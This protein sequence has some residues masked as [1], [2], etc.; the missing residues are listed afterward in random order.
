MK[1]FLLLLLPALFFSF[2]LLAG[3]GGG[4]STPGTPGPPGPPP[5]CAASPAAGNT[6][7]TATPI[8]NLNGYCG[9]TAATYT[10]DSWSQL[11]NAFCGSIE[12]NSFLTFVAEGTSM[13]FNV[14]VSSNTSGAGIQIMVFSAN[15]CSG[16]VTSYTCWSPGTISQGSTTITANGLT[17]GNT[18]Y[19]M[20][21][22]NSGHVCNYV[23]SANAG[24]Q[25]PVSVAPQSSNICLGE[26]ATLTADGG[27]GT[28]S[29]TASPDLNTLAGA[30]VTATPSA[31]GTYQYTVTSSTGNNLCPSSVSAVATVQVT[32]CGC[33][34]TASNSGPACPGSTVNLTASNVANASS[35]QWTG[36]NGFTSSDQN[37][38][39]IT[40]PTTP[41]SYDYTVTATTV[42]GPCT[43]TTTVVVKPV[44][45]AILPSNI[46]SCSQQPVAAATFTSNPPGA[47][48]TWT[49]SDASIGLAASGTGNAGAFTTANTTAA[50]ITANITVTPTLDGCVGSPGVYTITVSPVPTMDAVLPVALCN[51][52]TTNA[53]PFSSTLTGVT[54]Q[55]TNPNTAIGLAASGTGNIPSFTAVNA[56]T[57]PVSALITV[58]PSQGTC[59]G[60]PVTFNI[61]V[62]ALPTVD[63]GTAATVCE[64]V[65]V[66]LTGTGAVSY[67]WDNGVTDNTPFAASVTT[68]Y[69]VIG[70]DANGC[71]NT[72]QVIITVNPKPTADAGPD[73]AICIGAQATLTGSSSAPFIWNNGVSNGVA[74]TPAS[75]ATYTLTSTD[76]NNCQNTDQVVVTVNPL[77]NIQAGADQ[78]I[79][80]EH[81]IALTATGGVSYVWAGGQINGQ[82]FQ[83]ALGNNAYAV[84]GTD[85][86]GCI[87]KDTVY[88]RVLAIPVADF[89]ADETQGYPTLNVNFT[90]VSTNAGTYIWNFGDGTPAYSTTSMAT[91]HPY[92]KVGVYNVELIASNGTC[93]DKTNVLITVLPFPDPVLH[94]P[95]VFTPNGDNAN[96][97]FW[98]DVEFAA[99]IEVQIFN[100]WGNLMHE[101]HGFDDRWDGKVNGHEASDGVYFHK[102]SVVDLNGKTVEGH[103]SITLKR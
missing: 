67:T 19:I 40:V 96:D 47:T 33:T 7:A 50:P 13:S 29:W 64:G 61:T 79:C 101:L 5:S 37:P 3:G 100:R 15:N 65:S 4:T 32:A 44:P 52:G 34:V 94:V 90:N 73:Q 76:A 93:L 71:Q 8:C 26:S 78:L 30:S 69:H 49:N 89:I 66:T 17:P 25:V 95:N 27:S 54:Y 63:A 16:A 88:I 98:I 75:T 83:P 74:F 80:D 38:A 81:P 82:L 14:W 87:N 23:I 91:F 77:P 62:N 56:G 11:T 102:Y 45:F 84:V 31:V 42:N 51:G 28:Y 24:V 12:N 92:P 60:T 22:G 1:K 48:Y 57:S 10:S 59:V 6:C 18:Y 55:W 85:A 72:D 36:P 21:D 43:S 68:T 2:S 53:I 86:N 35:Y 103:G 9:S 39:G 58:T 99:S 41:G 97:V 20:I 46:T 70:T